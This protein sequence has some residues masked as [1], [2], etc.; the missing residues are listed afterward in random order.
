MKLRT[1][2]QIIVVLGSLGLIAGCSNTIRGV[3]QDTAN[4]V[5]ATQN[6]GQNVAQ[7]AR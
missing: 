6:A 1:F 7:A 5:D 3:G 4:A 2:S